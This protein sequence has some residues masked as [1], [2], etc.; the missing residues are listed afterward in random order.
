MTDA[1]RDALD[2]GKELYHAML[3]CAN[4]ELGRMAEKYRVT[5][6]CW[7]YM[8]RT[9]TEGPIW[10]AFLHFAA[11]YEALGQEQQREEATE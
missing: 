3:A 2:A 4:P 7:S 1:Q 10:S 6:W 11:A 5:N 9:Y 8:T